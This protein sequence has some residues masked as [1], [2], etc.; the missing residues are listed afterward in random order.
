MTREGH[1]GI[2]RGDKS[3]LH[4]GW[5]LHDRACSSEFREIPQMVNF[6]ICKLSLNKNCFKNVPV[7]N[8]MLKYYCSFLQS[9]TLNNFLTKEELYYNLVQPVSS[10]LAFLLLLNT[11]GT[12]LPQGICTCYFSALINLLPP[13]M[14]MAPFLKVSITTSTQRDL[15]LYV[16]YYLP[17]TLYPSFLF[18]TL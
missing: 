12:L 18:I 13:D 3:R 2:S 14:P 4:L 11:Y 7:I 6:T 17:G 1:E 15:L 5:W 10:T 8:T 16:K 9:L